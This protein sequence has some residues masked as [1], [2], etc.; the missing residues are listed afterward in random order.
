M[1]TVAINFTKP[2]LKLKFAV[3]ELIDS[4]TGSKP[5]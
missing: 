5:M 2:K 4:V 3:K 1:V